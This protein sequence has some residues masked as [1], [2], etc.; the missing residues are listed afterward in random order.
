MT[1]APPPTSDILTESDGF[2]RPSWTLF[3]NSLYEGDSGTEWEPT[4]QNLGTTGAP[5]I[6]GRFYRLGG[7]NLIFFRITIIPATNTTSTAGTTYC[8]NFPVSIREDGV[9][10]SVSGNLGGALGH[11]VAVNNRIYTP[12][13]STITDPVTIIGMAEAR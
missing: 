8:D 2:P 5:T 6:S 4:F 10:M 1:Y 9:C 13:W 11:V 12:A 7:L 3:F